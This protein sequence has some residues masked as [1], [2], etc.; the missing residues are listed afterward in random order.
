MARSQVSAR[1]TSSGAQSLVIPAMLKLAQS[2]I[3]VEGKEIPP[4]PGMT[5]T[6]EI[7][8]GERRDVSYVLSPLGEIV[9]TRRG[10]DDFDTI[11]EA[12]DS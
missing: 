10:R 7:K 2:T 1:P 11:A 5:I 8:T 9:S 3:D 12:D 4:T 6:V